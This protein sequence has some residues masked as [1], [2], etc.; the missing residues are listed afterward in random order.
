MNNSN[1]RVFVLVGDPHFFLLKE[2]RKK[3]IIIQLRKR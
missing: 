1:M 2:K 3:D